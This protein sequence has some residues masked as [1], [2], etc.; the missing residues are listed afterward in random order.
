MLSDVTVP[1]PKNT[2][3]T[4]FDVDAARA[5]L[6]SG[7]PVAFPPFDVLH[8]PKMGLNL[9][10]NMRRDPIQN[11]WRDGDF[12][13]I[14][15]LNTLKGLV[16]KDAH[17][18]DIGSNVGNHALF[19]ASRMG[20]ARVIAIEPNPIAMAALVAN[21]VV[22]GLQDVIDLSALGVGLSDTSEAGFGMRRRNRNLGATKMV[23]GD[24]ELQVHPGDTLFEG[25]QV[26]LIKIDVEGM[27]M[28]V[29]GGMENTIARTRP[30]ILIEVDGEN[31]T[32]FQE[33]RH[34]RNYQVVQ[35]V[36]H[37]DKNCNYILKAEG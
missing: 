29:L 32:H 37:S 17:I 20:A 10:L 6:A 35:T 24:G 21:V 36:R 2:D 9:C 22:N 12:Y 3:E 8:V 18:I 14:E 16:K 30:V 31:E 5:A 26:D 1:L 28:K 25:E 7:A 23:A 4:Y 27:E 13:E 19:F 34:A 33:W 11:A 15:E